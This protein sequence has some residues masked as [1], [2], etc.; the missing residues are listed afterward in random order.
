MG[1]DD[2]E[3]KVWVTLYWAGWAVLWVCFAIFML[4]CLFGWMVYTWRS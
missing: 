3:S 1:A 2:E 4:M